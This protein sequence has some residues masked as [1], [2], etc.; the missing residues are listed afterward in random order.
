MTDQ[1]KEKGVELL[2]AARAFFK[3]CRDAKQHGAVQWI[4]AEDGSCVIYTRGEYLDTLMRNIHSVPG[5]GVYHFDAA[6]K[7]DV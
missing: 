5:Q 4:I 1:R 2:E 7:E 6:P 3:A